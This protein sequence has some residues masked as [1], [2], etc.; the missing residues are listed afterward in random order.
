MRGEKT[1]KYPFY[2]QRVTNVLKN[3][4]H[5]TLDKTK[6]Q[7]GKRGSKRTLMPVMVISGHLLR[8]RKDQTGK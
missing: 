1:P 3:Y 8:G 6:C 4:S 5:I 7:K 2:D